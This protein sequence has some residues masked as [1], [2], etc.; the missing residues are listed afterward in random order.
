MP[1]DSEDM[2]KAV[3]SFSLDLGQPGKGVQGKKKLL[4]EK[5]FGSTKLAVKIQ[6]Q[7]KF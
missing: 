1:S 7:Q 6:S 4:T 5:C 2:F 3:K